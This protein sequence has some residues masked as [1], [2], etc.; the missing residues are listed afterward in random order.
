MTHGSMSEMAIFHQ[1]TH[2]LP[3]NPRLKYRYIALHQSLLSG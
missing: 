3:L 2:G 1:L